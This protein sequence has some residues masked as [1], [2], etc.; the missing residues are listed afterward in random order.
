MKPI[1]LFISSVQKE[2]AAERAALRDYLRGDALMRRFFDAFFFEDI[3][4]KDRRADSLYLD[5]VAACNVYVGLFGYEYGNE[6]AR[7]ISPTQREF[8]LATEKGKHRLIF[9]KGSDEKNRHPKMLALI[10]KAGS[11]LIRRRFSSAPELISNLYAALV[12]YLEEHELIRTVPFDAAPC[13]GAT[14]SDLDEN[15]MQRFIREARHARGFP[16][17]EGTPYEELLTHLNLMDKGRPVNAAILLFARQ[18][19]RFLL[20]SE[21]KCAHFHG[22]EVAKP[23]P[24]YQVYKGTVFEMV[25]QAVDFVMSKLD[26]RIGTREKSAKA[27]SV[28]EIPREVVTEGIVNAVAHRDYASKGSVQVMLFSDRLEVWNPGCLPSTITIERLREPHGSVP[29]NPLLAEPLYLTQYIER[30]GT[31]TRDMIKGC[32]EAGLREPDFRMTD[33][34]VLTIWRTKPPSGRVQVSGKVSGKMSGKMS[35]KT[36]D[37]II[38]LMRENP[39]ITIPEIARRLKRTERTIERLINKLKAK[40]IIGRVG[41]AKGGHWEVLK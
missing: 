26:L 5:E 13:P 35:G 34:F 8:D 32:L 29:N 39:E 22:N 1:R 19:Q 6:D 21:V 12:D 7:G 36:S 16:L 18:P 3:P 25:D 9:L 40:E 11:Q 27:P 30:M 33:G 38:A 2:F 14:L 10:R 37:G 31:G 24:S 15:K 28:Y 17:R 23:I 4:A 20:S 41:P